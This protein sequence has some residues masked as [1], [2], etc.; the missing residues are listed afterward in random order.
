MSIA[1]EDKVL[2]LKQRILFRGI[3]EEEIEEIARRMKEIS[4]AA[5]EKLFSEGEKG[6]LF[7]IIYKGKVRTWITDEG[8]EIELAILEEGDKVGEE[9]MLLNR[10]QPV[11]AAAAE[12]TVLFALDK[13]NFEWL[14][15]NYPDA[16][17]FLY[18]LAESRLQA[19]RYRFDWL[20]KGETIH[21]LTRRHPAVLW[22]EL[23]KPVTVFV[24][25]VFFLFY[26]MKVPGLT[27]VS[28]IMGVVLIV[29]S[30][31]WGLWE[32]L[33]WQ[34]DYFIITN[35]RVVWL[36]QVLL[37]AA[38]RREAP[39]A[40]V[41]SVD[42]KTS[43]VGR[44][45]DFGNILVRTFTGTGSMRLTNVNRP[46]QFK[47]QIEELLIRVREKTE[48][49]EEERVRQSI[50]QGLGLEAAPVDD[51]I[52][53]LEKPEEYQP[54][55]L[56]ILRTREVS[57]DGLTITYHRHWLILLAKTWWSLLGMIGMVVFLFYGL[58][59]KFTVLTFKLPPLSFFLL[60]FVGTLV[61]GA[62]LAY[63][64]QDWKNDIYKI[65][66]DDM[67]IDAEKKPFG[68]E[69]SRSAP[70][71]NII[72]LEHQRQGIIRL[73]LNFGLVKVVVAD[74]TLTFYDVHDPAQ[75]Q[76]DIYYRQEQINLR[77][78]EAEIEEDRKH[79][80]KWLRVYHEIWQEEEKQKQNNPGENGPGE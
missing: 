51:P 18:T 3:P 37:Q 77:R 76:Q 26:L 70:I 63:H 24:I 10:P 48:S 80:T 61:F 1:F 67:I 25:G 12:E 56:T 42:V 30:F 49:T 75:V 52:F 68:E 27:L 38:S 16:E 6:Y 41:Q 40:A 78:Q 64:Y 69:I 8:E 29:I 73:L 60:W 46:K 34:N 23:T 28:E 65:T 14:L 58:L 36:E 39:L 66:K 5:G 62:F 21:I 19:R 72:S 59:N 45:L 54:I 35:Q 20:H 57:P 17:E 55:G 15:I 2:F 13:H 74:A 11:S 22:L 71:K 7:Y 79:L 33:D 32:V 44:I 43:Q 50:R 53:H 47:G 9:G 4:H 31:L